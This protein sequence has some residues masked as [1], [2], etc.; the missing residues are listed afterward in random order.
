MKDLQQH[1]FELKRSWPSSLVARDQVGR[2]SGGVIT[3]KYIANLDC[4]GCGPKERLRIGRKVAYPVDALCNWLS[5]RAKV[6]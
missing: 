6:I 5:E 2:F 1:F 4:R 3:P